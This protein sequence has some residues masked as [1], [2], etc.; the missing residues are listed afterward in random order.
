MSAPAAGHD[1]P[2]TVT[3][4]TGLTDRLIRRHRNQQSGP[5]QRAGLLALQ[6]ITAAGLAV[7]AYVHAD[8]ASAYQSAG[9]AISQAALF[10]IEAGAASAAA[11]IVLVIAG[12]AGFALAA[13]VA[14]RKPR[15]RAGARNRGRR[16]PRPYARWPP[17]RS[18]RWR[19]P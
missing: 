11:L 19:C 7:D 4:H 2:R 13:V 14:A 18:A 12:R 6:L 15:L 8:L 16:T 9:T 1:Q 3:R 5:L 10:R 17:A